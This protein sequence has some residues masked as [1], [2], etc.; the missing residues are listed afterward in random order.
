MITTY[1]NLKSELTTKIADWQEI[2]CRVYRT[3][4]E[5]ACVGKNNLRDAILIIDNVNNEH[6]TT[7]IRCKACCAQ[8][9][10]NHVTV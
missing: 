4:T 9:G 2:G 8:K 3:R 10:G 1:V 7:I 5:C 6:V